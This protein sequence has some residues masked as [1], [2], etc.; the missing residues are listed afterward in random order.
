[1]KALREKYAG[2][3]SEIEIAS[4]LSAATLEEDL[5]ES[6]QKELVEFR[7]SAEIERDRRIQVEIRQVQSECIKRE[8]EGDY[9]VSLV[10]LIVFF[11]LRMQNCFIFSEEGF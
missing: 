1:M 11:S 7:K 6:Q 4:K 8:R 3:R 5:T 10:Y 9:I 2:K